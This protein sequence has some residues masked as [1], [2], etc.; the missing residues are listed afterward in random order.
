MDKDD[1]AQGDK[2]QPENIWDTH[3][4]WWQETFTNGVD[5]EYEEQI[6]PMVRA[7]L[8]G[9]QDILD[10]GCGEG[11]V[12]RL[13]ETLDPAPKT[14]VGI[15]GSAA[16]LEIAE[17]RGGSP[18]FV[19]G[20]AGDLPFEPESFD[21]AVSVL[22]LEHIENLDS[23]ISEAARVLRPGGR[24][25]CLLNHP[26]LQT[27]GSGWI[28]DHILD[29][30]YWRIGAYLAEETSMEEVEP[31]V[32]LPFV[33]RPLS[34]YVNLLAKNGL[35]LTDMQEPPPPAG[36]ISRAAEYENAA[37]IPRLLF[38]RAEKFQLS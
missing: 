23:V 34:A 9:A 14:I 27:P 30:Q 1:K 20:D 16:Q 33:H 36:F 10:I 11:Q 12:C 29:E 15:D 2:A 21:A 8:S 3:A 31:G 18:R 35:F 24:L 25:L 37:T 6:L 28:D 32:V 19:L 4:Q 17:Q 22:V 13:A 26:L 38:L 5:P 7:H